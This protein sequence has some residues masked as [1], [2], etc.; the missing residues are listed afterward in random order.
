MALESDY[1]SPWRDGVFYSGN[2]KVGLAL[3]NWEG[4]ASSAL[5]LPV[6]PRIEVIYSSS[7][8]D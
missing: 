5:V 8:F 7:V 6:D 3:L 4:Q 2:L 1:S